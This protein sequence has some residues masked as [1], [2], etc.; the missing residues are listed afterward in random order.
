MDEVERGLL[1]RPVSLRVVN[2]EGDVWRD[3]ARLDGGE[4]S[5]DYV[6]GGEASACELVG[7]GEKWGGGGT[8]QHR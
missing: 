5:S 3:P 8:Q 6:C 1:P 4:V 2:D 7:G